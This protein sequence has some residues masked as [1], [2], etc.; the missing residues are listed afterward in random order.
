VLAT[1]ERELTAGP[2]P[3]ARHRDR[4]A[5][6]GMSDDAELAAAIRAGRLD[7]RADEVRDAVWESV[8]DKLRVANPGYLEDRDRA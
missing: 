6:L 7:D 1:V 5:S 2:A 4:L 3:L 8:L